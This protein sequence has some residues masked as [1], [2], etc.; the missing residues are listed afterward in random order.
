MANQS[1]TMT[2]EIREAARKIRSPLA[3]LRAVS[4]GF[5]ARIA[6]ALGRAEVLS[7]QR[8]ATEADREAIGAELRSYR[9]VLEKSAEE[10]SRLG[11]SISSTMHRAAETEAH[12]LE[13]QKRALSLEKK[14]RE[15]AE[16]DRRLLALSEGLGRSQHDLV[17]L[18]TRLRDAESA[19]ALLL[20]QTREVE[21]AVRGQLEALDG[22]GARLAS[23]ESAHAERTRTLASGEG[24]LEAAR[25]A[26]AAALADFERRRA[27]LEE[28]ERVL[29]D[30]QQRLERDQ[31]A[32]NEMHAKL[33]VLVERA[34]EHERVMDAHQKEWK[35]RLAALDVRS[36]E[37]DERKHA[38]D[39]ERVDLDAKIAHLADLDERNENLLRFKAYLD[40]DQ[41][42][43][44]AELA[45]VR[46]SQKGTLDTWEDLKATL[47]RV[48]EVER[49]VQDTNDAIERLREDTQ[50]RER[51]ASEAAKRRS[52]QL[53]TR[54]REIL[55]WRMQ[56]EIRERKVQERYNE[57]DTVEARK[58]A[59]RAEIAKLESEH[60]ARIAEWEREQQRSRQLWA[61]RRAEAEKARELYER[62]VA[63]VEARL[64]EV[65]AREKE[66]QHRAEELEERTAKLAE[67]ELRLKAAEERVRLLEEQRDSLNAVIASLSTQIGAD[68]RSPEARLES[69]LPRPPLDAPL[70]L[71]GST[72]P[73]VQRPSS[74]VVAK[75]SS[76]NGEPAAG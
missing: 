18:G 3:A 28:R 12:V 66:H 15:L 50:R 48:L 51:E 55:N 7:E 61:E 13:V 75:P 8:I 31:A 59:V 5:R 32:V 1:D 17:E 57:L 42:R 63:L 68:W 72:P 41:K 60:A 23:D 11:A 4:G 21:E 69:P 62:N 58:Q 24:A 20:S 44:N 9:A 56:S 76:R 19:N 2:A 22:R 73:P 74:A 26:H 35:E 65:A 64:A 10:M 70:D 46:E 67:R 52:L 34:G 37:L 45:G 43:L 14:E 39:R 54:E 36:Q 49:R 33:V 6:E 47:A 71:P 53:D 29:Q 25:A 16:Q 38:Y 30:L 27:S 40:D